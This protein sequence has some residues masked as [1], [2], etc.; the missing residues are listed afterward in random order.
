MKK[1]IDMK[2]HR[3]IGPK[4]VINSMPNAKPS[5]GEN[6][7]FCLEPELFFVHNSGLLD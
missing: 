1:I 6:H 3:L 2:L 5:E 4:C 7:E